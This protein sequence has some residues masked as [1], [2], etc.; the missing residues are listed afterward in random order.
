[1]EKAIDIKNKGNKYY[2]QNKFNEALECYTKAIELCPP[3][4][5]NEL[6][7]FYQNRAAVYEQLVIL[8]IKS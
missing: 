5:T 2:Q 8:K 7:K 3:N 6:P 1:M 4:D